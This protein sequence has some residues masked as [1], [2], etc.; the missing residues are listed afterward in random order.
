[1]ES[2]AC[3]YDVSL[4]FCSSALLE[5]VHCCVCEEDLGA[6]RIVRRKIDT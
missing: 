5:E 4:I 1:M 2:F 3:I 6:C